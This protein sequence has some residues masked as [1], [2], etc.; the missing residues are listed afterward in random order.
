VFFAR[1][2]QVVRAFNCLF[3]KTEQPLRQP[4]GKTEQL[5]TTTFA[6]GLK[7]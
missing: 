7:N 3:G 1:A 5:K 4:F 2:A 6:G